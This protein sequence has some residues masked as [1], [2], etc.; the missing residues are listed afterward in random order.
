MLRLILFL[1]TLGAPVQAD[2]LA[3]TNR[4]GTGY[5]DFAQASARLADATADCDPAAMI[6][7]YHAAFDAWLG[8]AHVRLG[9]VEQDGYAL[10]I[11][12]WPDP[13]ALGAKA[14][15]GLLAGD[16]A[17]L[18]PKSFAE[19]SVAARGLMGLERLLYP[20]DAPGEETCPLIRATAADLARMA[21]Q[22]AA[23]WPA[24]ATL[25]IHAGK[26]GNTRFLT[27]AEARQTLLTQIATTLDFNASQ[28]LGRPMGS[29]NTPRP[30]RAEARASGRSQRNLVLSLRALRAMAADLHPDIPR[31]LAAF[32]RAIRL[33]EALDDPVFAGVESPAKR[34]KLDIVQQAVLAAR[35]TVLS[36]LAPALGVGLGFNALDGD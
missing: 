17:R 4:I 8:V 35:D 23:D 28:R 32:D 7:A 33:A 25:L 5:A 14:Q 22:I 29:F 20:D 15:R 3:A 21:Q 11:A 19:E 9:P 12:F 31:S 2:V 27:E 34:L 18:Q 24:F 30:T 10:A 26:P 6:P 13:K 16:P 1:L 36:E